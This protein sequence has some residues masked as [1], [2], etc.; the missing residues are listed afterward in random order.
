M[1]DQM[2]VA[3]RTWIGGRE[4][5]VAVIE[6]IDVRVQLRVRVDVYSGRCQMQLGSWLGKWP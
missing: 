5:W 2:G 4:S 3:G 1:K 6:G